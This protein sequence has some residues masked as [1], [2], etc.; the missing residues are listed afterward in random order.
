MV[1]VAAFAVDML[2]NMSGTRCDTPLMKASANGNQFMAGTGR[3]GRVG[4]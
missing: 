4:G 2:D 3:G 1:V